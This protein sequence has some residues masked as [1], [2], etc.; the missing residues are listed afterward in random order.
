MLGKT[1]PQEN[2]FDA[3]IRDNFLPEEHELLEIR[4]RIDFSFIKEK[5]KDLYA[6]ELGRPSYP[7]EVMFKILFLEFYYN[8]SDVEV[9]GQLKFNVLFRY[10]VG[11]S[12]EDPIPDDTS[13][14]V[15]RKRLGEKRFEEIFDEFIMQCKEKGLLKEK[16]K[17][18][19]ATHIIADVAIPNTTTLLKEGR[20]RILKAIKKEKKNLT[21]SLKKYFP[22]EKPSGK[23]GKEDL[24]KVVMQKKSVLVVK[25]DL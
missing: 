22:E 4:K 2:F 17:A 16:L 9:A 3:Y 12:A 13:L 5:T 10:F 21:E 8:L 19:D 23:I 7:P 18:I 11:L 20:K 6:E 25:K 14:V 24:I 1:D 15:F